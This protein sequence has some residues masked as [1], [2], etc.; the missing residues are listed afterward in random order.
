ML[1]L[2]KVERGRWANANLLKRYL[3]CSSEL[4]DEPI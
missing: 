2:E 1:G 4:F 3:A